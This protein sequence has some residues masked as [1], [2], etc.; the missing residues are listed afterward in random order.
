MSDEEKLVKSLTKEV[1]DMEN[2]IKNTKLYIFKK[3]LIKS[4]IV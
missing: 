3:N 1:K 2:M 4:G